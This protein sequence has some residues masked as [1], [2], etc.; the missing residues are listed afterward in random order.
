MAP[1]GSNPPGG[2]KGRGSCDGSKPLK[3]R[4]KAARFFKKAQ[5]RTGERELF[6]DHRTGDKA[7]KGEAYERWG[8]K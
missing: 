2:R 8:L 3:R 4:W 6:F 7:L 1:T 5:E